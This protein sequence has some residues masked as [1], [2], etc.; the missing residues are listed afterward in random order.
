MDATWLQLSID[1]TLAYHSWSPWLGPSDDS[2]RTAL[3]AD[4][5]PEC[6]PGP[7]WTPEPW[8][9]GHR[10]PHTRVSQSPSRRGKCLG[11]WDL[12]AQ[13][14]GQLGWPGE[15][16]MRERTLRTGMQNHPGQ[17]SAGQKRLWGSWGALLS[18]NGGNPRCYFGWGCAGSSWT[19]GTN[20][21]CDNT[22]L[23][24]DVPGHLAH[25]IA[26][27]YHLH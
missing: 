16:T 26:S 9:P 24:E 17:E 4:G 27:M 6:N 1:C 2:H 3:A 23:A 14:P 12:R 11:K 7:S 5:V 13:W 8:G 18:I 15:G 19:D 22:S 25:H 10:H 20:R 21:R